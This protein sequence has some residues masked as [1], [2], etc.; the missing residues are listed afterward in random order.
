MNKTLSRPCRPS[1]CWKGLGRNHWR[2]EGMGVRTRISWRVRAKN[3]CG[4]CTT[5][6]L[7]A[8]M[9]WVASRDWRVILWQQPLSTVIVIR[10]NCSSCVSCFR[11][12]VLYMS[13]L[14]YFNHF[15]TSKYASSSVRTLLCLS[16]KQN[17][18]LN[19]IKNDSWS[20]ISDWLFVLLIDFSDYSAWFEYIA[21]ENLFWTV[22][23]RRVRFNWPT[24]IR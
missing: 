14:L 24:V 22:E 23:Y 6:S 21:S 3:I 1:W 5:E 13:A 18:K 7:Y 17:K 9:V 16:F 8:I 10:L 19:H 15:L 2:N 12:S 20:F 11:F 4:W